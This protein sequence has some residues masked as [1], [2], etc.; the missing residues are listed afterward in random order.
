MKRKEFLLTTLAAIP[1]VAFANIKSADTKNDKPFVVRA[2][3]GRFGKSMKYKGI[4][5]NDIIIS[6]KD[7]N[8][9]L[10]VFAY[11]GLSKIGP[12]THLHFNQ[13]EMFNVVEGSYRFVVGEETMELNAGDTI[14]LPRDIPHSWIQLTDLG[15]LIYAVQ[16]AGTLE[17]F[18]IEMD[19]LTKPPTKE[20][21]EKIHLKHGMKLIGPGLKL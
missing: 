1:A 3:N 18:F 13:D 4:H 14:F 2:G 8:D 10:S 15:K 7:T 12:S 16:P 19:G 11:T 20:E 17:D 21:A 5:P 6:R 9:A